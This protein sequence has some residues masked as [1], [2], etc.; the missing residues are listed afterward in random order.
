MLR[1]PRTQTKTINTWCRARNAPQ[2]TAYLHVVTA[3]HRMLTRGDKVHVHVIVKSLRAINGEFCSSLYM[4]FE[5]FNLSF[6]PE[7]KI[8]MGS[9]L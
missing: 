5:I 8:K 7:D 9:C 1:T 2:C 6:E 3:M 4:N